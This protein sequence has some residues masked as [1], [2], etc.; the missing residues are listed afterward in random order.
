MEISPLRKSDRVEQFRKFQVG[1]VKGAE[2]AECFDCELK[3]KKVR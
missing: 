2:W 3:I 1:Q